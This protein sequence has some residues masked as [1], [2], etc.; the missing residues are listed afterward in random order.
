MDE[1]IKIRCPY[2]S[3]SLSVKRIPDIEK[4]SVTCPV[5][6]RKSPFLD[7]K[8]TI[9][10]DDPTDYDGNGH[11]QGCSSDPNTSGID[12]AENNIIGHI[13]VLR[14]GSIFPLK[15]GRNVIGR[16]ADS[17]KATIQI[18][19]GDNR[20]ISR[21]HLVV[22]VKRVLGQGFVHTVSLFKENVNKT[23]ING[24]Q[25]QP[26]EE[27][28]LKHGCRIGLPDLMLRFELSNGEDTERTDY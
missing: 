24:S 20:R 18:P 28:P 11:G 5:C 10:K 14:T 23:F 27:F 25:L 8:Q 1:L 13:C 9:H 3:A 7:F 26:G 2:C 22:N 21:E 12:E 16:K 19:T 17:S 4:K 15:Q 6:K